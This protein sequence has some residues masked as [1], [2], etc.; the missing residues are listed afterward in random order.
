MTLW[1]IEPNRQRHQ[2][3]DSFSPAFYVHGPEASLRYLQRVLAS[4]RWPLACRFTERVNLWD[5]NTWKVL[6]VSVPRPALFRSVC[7]FVRKANPALRLFNSDFILA[8]LYCFEKRLFPLAHCSLE[9]DSQGRVLSIQNHDDEWAL[10]YELPPLQIMWL[11]LRQPGSGT[12]VHK[13]RAYLEV[14]IEGECYEILGQDEPAAET[15]SRLLKQYDPDL[16]VSEGGDSVILPG[17]LRQADRGN[18]PLALSRDPDQSF[19]RSRARSYASYGRIL[20]KD[21]ATTLFGRLHVDTRNSFIADKCDLA[22]LWELVRLTKLPVQYAARTTTGTGISTMQMEVMYRDG[23]LIPEQKSEPEDFKRPDQLLLSDRGGL[24]Y[25]PIIGFHETVAELDWPSMFPTIMAKFNVSSETINCRCCPASPLIPELGY[26]VCQRRAGIAGRTVAPLIEKR[27]QYKRLIRAGCSSDLQET[28]NLRCDAAKWL[29]VCCFGYLGYKNARMGKIEAHEAINAIARESLLRAKEVSEA[30]GFRILHA[31]VDSVYV[32]KAG[33][34]R[35]DFELLA[36]RIEQ[37]T[38]LPIALDAIYRYIVFLPSKRFEGIPVPNRFFAVSESGELKVRGL[39]CRKH[40][41]PPLAVRMQ[42]EMLAV[43]SEAWDWEGYCRKLEEARAILD[44]YLERLENGNVRPEE[45][46]ISKRLTRVPCDY[47]K[48]SLSA[49]AAQQL[50]G[51]GVKLHPGEAVRYVITNA[52]AAIPNERVRAYTLWDGCYGYDR[53]KYREILQEAF[54]PFG[55]PF[56]R[57]R[58]V[59]CRYH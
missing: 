39:E 26:R 11:K 55:E 20:F 23:I 13:E 25:P 47:Q 10:D 12:S 36:E 33:A 22:G 1:V 19:H 31:I 49:V 40:D 28:Y 35:H 46:V 43:L 14:E 29:L 16:L 5:G 53:K 27:Q 24:I 44:G 6:Q 58:Q 30:A 45:L 21:S 56:L 7:R 9:A 52:E 4:R 41:T 42:K 37:A 59:V 51:C 38:G 2:L 15:L 54:E 8:T 18:I 50:D 34:T 3:I 17:L 57:G 48:A 32:Q